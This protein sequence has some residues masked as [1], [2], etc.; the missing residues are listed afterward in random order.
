MRGVSLLP[1]LVACDGGEGSGVSQDVSAQA[2]SVAPGERAAS[3]TALQRGTDFAGRGL[4]D[5]AERELDAAVSLDPTSA[6]AR[7]AR[8][9]MHF[10]QRRVLLG[11]AQVDR[12]RLARALEDFRAAADLDPSREIYP[13]F[14]GLAA[15]ETRDGFAEAA[16][17][18]RA[19]L[20]L[21]PSHADARVRLGTAL[22]YLGE[23]DE[24]RD[25]LEDAVRRNPAGIEENRELG[26]LYADEGDW[27]LAV[28]CFRRV[29]EAD[30]RATDTWIALADALR[31]TGREEEA[32]EA[33]AAYQT[34]RAAD[35]EA[36]ERA[37]QALSPEVV[38]DF[39]AAT[40]HLRA[41]RTEE[42]LAAFEAVVREH[43][44][45]SAAHANIGSIHFRANR[46]DPA[47]AAFAEAVRLAPDN[48]FAHYHLGLLAQGA[49]DAPAALAAFAE[50]VRADPDHDAARLQL[51][52]LLVARGGEGD[53]A[54]ARTHVLAV[55]ARNPENA[56]AR[57]LLASLPE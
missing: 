13:Y 11:A 6:A 20:R 57:K 1:L 32:D 21:R 40:A 42:A 5:E 14:V 34:H 12:A 28:A 17:A 36:R 35:E 18:F 29:V 15:M 48:S 26:R 3:Q 10:D 33:L 8:G 19:T 46:P 49:G 7:F 51:A 38:E 43:P 39:Q 30:P 53:R 16:D 44:E 25:V 47:R 50:A 24:A 23:F 27:G 37:S 31:R 52:G 41:G 9:R 4:Y 55:L 56:Q 45:V 2:P 54:D 22:R